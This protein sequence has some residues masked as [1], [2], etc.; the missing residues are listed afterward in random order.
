MS[1]ASQGS[2]LSP[3]LIALLRGVI[4][5]EDDAR[6]WQQL[7]R[8]DGRVRDYV[9]LLGLELQLHEDE[10]FAFLQQREQQEDEP[11]LPRLIPRRRLSY[12][13]SLTLALLRR[14][15]AEHDAMS[16]EERVVLETDEVVEMV[17]T[18]L[19][20][21]ST[22]ARVVDRIQSTLRKIA[23]LGFIRFLDRGQ[24]RLEIKRILTAFVDAQWLSEFDQRL[25]EY[26]EY[27]ERDAEESDE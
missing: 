24:S 8:Y 27:A 26:A 13:V 19:S 10:G 15:L 7:M 9:S 14:R 23:E 16:G 17:R 20:G 12:P 6:L 18:F 4:Y 1:D 11:E 5:R 22:E 21:G 2:S 25:Q 3:V